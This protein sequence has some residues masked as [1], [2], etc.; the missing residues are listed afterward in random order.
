MPRTKKP[1]GTAVD[2]R[3]GRQAV[4]DGSGPL[5]KFSLPRRADGRPLDVRTRRMVAA[6]RADPV[7]Q[8]LSAVDRE[9][10]IRW[11]LS[12]DDW[13][14]A[15]ARAHAEPLSTGSMGQEVPSP[16]WGIA[17]QALDV[18][19]AMEQQ[20]GIGAL[21]RARLGLTI[22]KAQM[23]LEELNAMHEE[24]DDDEYDPR[25]STDS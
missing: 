4:L 6:L 7:S 14:K 20:M 13:I 11:A 19:V 23:T 15:L 17:K 22:G 10:V 16:W 3:N 1:A 21:N 8:A 2:R 25:L 18:A 12:V 9:I 24:G 5:A